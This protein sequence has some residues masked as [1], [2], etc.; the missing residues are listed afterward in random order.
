MPIETLSNGDLLIRVDSSK[1]VSGYTDL[2][3]L[4]M[5]NYII[6]EPSRKFCPLWE[7]Q[8]SQSS[9]VMPIKSDISTIAP[10]EISPLYTL[11]H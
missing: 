1:A 6:F 8:Y 4:K 10:G 2:I 7:F 3:H 5:F 9:T 11:P